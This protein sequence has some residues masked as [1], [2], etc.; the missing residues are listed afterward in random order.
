MPVLSLPKSRLL[1]SIHS[2]EKGIEMHKFYFS[3]TAG[4]LLSLLLL[5]SSTW[6]QDATG[7]IA[8]NITDATGA[9]VP[10][11]TVVVT[12]LDTR[13]SKQALTN[14]QGFYQVLQ[15]PIGHYEV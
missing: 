5:V 7:K 9:L 4:A 8:G 3:E 15:L 6:A 14:N 10:G 1:R 13:T 12:N 2:T 11:A